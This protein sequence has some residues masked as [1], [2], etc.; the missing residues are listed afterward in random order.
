MSNYRN[1]IY[2]WEGDSTQPY[3]NNF[4]WTSGII[5]LP[6]RKA[7]SCARVLAVTGDRQDYYD[8]VEAQRQVI[9]RNN[10]KIS[11]GI[12]GGSIGE[13]EIGANIEING[14]NLETVP[15]VADYSGDF[16]LIV[17]I[18]GDGTL[19]FTKNVYSNN[20][21][22]RIPGGIRAREWYVSITGNVRVRRFDMADSVNELKA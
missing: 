17:K 14:D 5:L 15:T 7:F 18:Y 13:E 19:L 4:T 3:P 22:F 2:Q 9:A 21:P 8:D 10:A 6:Y 12:M 20:K 11:L 1:N 16:N